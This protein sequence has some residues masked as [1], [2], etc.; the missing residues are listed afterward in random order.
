MEVQTG[1]TATANF[2]F[3][4]DKSLHITD[5]GQY[6][7]APVILLET[8]TGAEVEIQSNNEVK[9][10]GGSVATHLEAGMD[11]NGN[12]GTGLQISPGAILSVTTSGSI[13]QT[14]GR[15]MVSG[16]ISSVD[17]TN[18]T[19]TILTNAGTEVMLKAN[20]QSN[21]ILGGILSGILELKSQIGTQVQADYDTSTGVIVEMQTQSNT[22]TDTASTVNGK[23]EAVNTLSGIITIVGDTGVELVLN[24]GTNT[25]ILVNGTA[26]SLTGLETSIGSQVTIIYNTQTNVASMV[27]VHSNTGGSV[28]TNGTLKAA[29]L[30]AGT[31]TITT[32]TGA[33]LVLSINS[34]TQV[35]ANGIV[36]NVSSLTTKIGSRVAVTYN[37]ETKVATSIT[38]NENTSD[39]VS[40]S[41]TL[42]VV[43]SISGTITIVIQDGTELVLHITSSTQ[44]TVN[45][46]ASS[47]TS[48]ATSI[49]S[50]VTITYNAQ[51]NVATSINIK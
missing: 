11:V 41:G 12:I 7:F 46:S 51:T 26:S 33:D 28:S 43:N 21:L 45:G 1:G 38:A 4:A 13:V 22:Q 47:T 37:A 18:G 44:V 29:D 16:I 32:Q 23:L 30:I 6:I 48:L 40:A 3:L 2:D 24:V 42:K 49:G 14:G 19:I 25:N 9:V 5:D 27:V 31:V 20:E 39:T 8:R 17:T 15:I 35:V 34:S 10:S 36:G 50:Q